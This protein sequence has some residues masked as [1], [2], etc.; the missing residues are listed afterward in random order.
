MRGAALKAHLENRRLS[1]RTQRQYERIVSRINGDPVKWLQSQLNNKTP[2]GTVLPLR[3]A[4]K[5]YLIAEKGLDPDVVEETLPKAKGRPHKLRDALTPEQLNLY[6]EQVKE[7]VPD[8]CQT[9]L[10]LLPMTGLRIGEMCSLTFENDTVKQG[11]RGFLFRGKRDKQ[12]FVPLSFPAQRI[13]DLYIESST[14]ENQEHLFMGYNDSPV[15]PDSVRRWTR[16]L[17]KSHSELEDLSPHLLRHTFATN[18]LR[19]GMELRNLQALLGHASIET[20]AKYMHPDAQ[21]LFDA[22]SALQ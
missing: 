8:P 19:G 12:R 22:L 16:K 18:A 20:T 9:I 6:K 11:V 2:I 15:R 4:I 17:S 3:A 13:L 1:L 10:L 21:M 14:T 5:H 7:T